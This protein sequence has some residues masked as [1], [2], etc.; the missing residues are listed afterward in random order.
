VD[1]LQEDYERRAEE[2][3]WT[4]ASFQIARRI[5]ENHGLLLPRRRHP[6]VSSGVG[7]ITIHGTAVAPRGCHWFIQREQAWPFIYGSA[8]FALLE[9]RDLDA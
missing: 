3:L 6:G 1:A 5:G 9:V 4:S 7:I 8:D 2:E